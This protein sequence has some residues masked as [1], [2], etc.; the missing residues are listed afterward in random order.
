VSLSEAK[1]MNPASEHSTP[2]GRGILLR[3]LVRGASTFS[4]RSPVVGI[5]SQHSATNRQGEHLTE[6]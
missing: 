4:H 5:G 2:S 3:S 1:K 6:P